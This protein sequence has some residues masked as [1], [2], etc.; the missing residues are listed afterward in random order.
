MAFAK[1]SG[2]SNKMKLLVAFPANR[3]WLAGAALRI[4]R[5]F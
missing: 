3:I 1:W 2:K 5:T 4:G